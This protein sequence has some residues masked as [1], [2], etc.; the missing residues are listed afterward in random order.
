MLAADVVC[1]A[2]RRHAATCER[3][4]RN[5]AAVIRDGEAL[6]EAVLQYEAALR[7]TSGW[8]NPLRYLG[9]LPL[10]DDQRAGTPVSSNGATSPGVKTPSTRIEVR[11][12]YTFH[13]DD[14]DELVAFVSGRFGTEVSDTRE[15]VDLLFKSESWDPDRYPPGL[16]DVDEV[17]ADISVVPTR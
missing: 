7:A 4:P 13:T 11:A 9:P 3:E 14:E 10:F 17:T 6:C 15:A 2:I 16:M 5:V 12:R 8:S 1:E